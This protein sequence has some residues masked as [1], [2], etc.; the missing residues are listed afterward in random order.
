M[1]K[2][3]QLKGFIFIICSVIL[4]ITAF[5]TLRSPSHLN[6]VKGRRNLHFPA[7]TLV[8]VDPLNFTNSDSACVWTAITVERKC[9][10]YLYHNDISV[11]SPLIRT[12]VINTPSYKIRGAVSRE[13]SQ[14]VVSVALYDS[15][16]QIVSSNSFSGSW[17]FLRS[18]RNV[19]GETILYSLGISV[20]ENTLERGIT[21]DPGAFALFS[22]AKQ[23]AT[24][25]RYDRAISYL[26]R[27][28]DRD[29]FFASAC[30][31]L[32]EIYRIN[33]VVD[34]AEMW[35]VKAQSINAAHAKPVW[36]QSINKEQPLNLLLEKSRSTQFHQP[37]SGYQFKIITVATSN[38]IVGV[39]IIDPAKI[40]MDIEM[41]FNRQGNYC[42][43]FIKTETTLLA[44]NAGFFEM[45][46]NHSL[47][48]SGLIIKGDSL[49][50]PKTGHGGSGIFCMTRG[51][52]EIRWSKDTLPSGQYELAFQCGPVIVEPGGKMG[53]YSND[54]HRVNRS[55]IGVMQGK[56][57][58][59]IIH[60][61]NDRGLSLYEFAE[62][63][64]TP[65]AEGGVGCDAALNLDGG[66]SSQVCYRD[67]GDL[68]ELKG[69]W[70]VNS[71]IVVKKN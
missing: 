26:R 5:I 21:R 30:W 32:G 65:Q 41:Q 62:F 39:W 40:V 36:R 63:L 11:Q 53:I 42:A 19:L 43:D 66:S 16:G 28:C 69:L 3:P 58:L 33:G 48:P 9:I 24:A 12:T 35:S 27:A 51:K 15:S 70:K 68:H 31:T 37:G 14:V 57:V 4:L 34:S 56:V 49:I 8:Q 38:L 54:Y 71:A 10:E 20:G 64:Q 46:K 52:P 55:A 22:R 23:N 60:G 2:I 18:I 61:K 1:R 29:N 17:Q 44:L 25:E 6:V 7:G 47:S 59:A 13:D 67:G 50:S 45:D